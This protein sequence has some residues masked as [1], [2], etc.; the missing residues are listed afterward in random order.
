MIYPAVASR[1][2]RYDTTTARPSGFFFSPSRV[3]STFLIDSTV[4]GTHASFSRRFLRV[5]SHIEST[6]HPHSTS[7]AFGASLNA[8]RMRF[9]LS[10]LS[11]SR[12]PVIAL[13][14]VMRASYSCFER[15]RGHQK[16][17]TNDSTCSKYFLGN[18]ISFCSIASFNSSIVANEKVCPISE[19]IAHIVICLKRFCCS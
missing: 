17:L 15:V 9:H 16:P 5:T 3:S 19:I 18:G 10:A 12:F 14:A 1:D 4:T 7:I 2:Q 8:I 11:V 13:S 6:S